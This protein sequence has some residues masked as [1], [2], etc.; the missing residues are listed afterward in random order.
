MRQNWKI[1]RAC[2]VRD[3]FPTRPAGRHLA[4]PPISPPPC[5][6]YHNRMTVKY[7]AVMD[8]FT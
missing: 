7:M 2:E 4:L 3:N 6:G 8:K 5:P 1:L